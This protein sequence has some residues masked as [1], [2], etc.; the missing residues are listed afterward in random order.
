MVI[1]AIS[2]IILVMMMIRFFINGVKDGYLGEG[3]RY[4]EIL[5]YI[6]IVW[7]YMLFASPKHFSSFISLMFRLN[8]AKMFSSGISIESPS[9]LERLGMVDIVCSNYG[10]FIAPTDYKVSKF[11]NDSIEYKFH[12]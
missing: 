3:Q 10:T 12:G 9:V 6:L 1:R 11:W 8:Q 2:W 5:D 4:I 7:S